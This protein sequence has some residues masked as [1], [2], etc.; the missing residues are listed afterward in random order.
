M[1]WN[2][3]I[4]TAFM[5]RLTSGRLGR[6]AAFAAVAFA[7][8]VAMLGTTLPT[9]LYDL[10]RARF[11]FSE[12]MVTVVFAVYAAGVIGALLVFGHVS[13]QV[14]RRRTLLAGLALS[15]LGAL[16]FLLANGLPLLVIGRILSGLSA[17]LFTGTATATLVDLAP[18]QPRGRAAFTATVA[19]TGGLGLGTL[20]AGIVSQWLDS[21]LQTVFWVDLAL[22]AATAVG[23]WLMPEP[24]AHPTRLNLRPQLPSIPAAVRT[25]FVQA[26][27]G[28]FAGFAVLGLFTAVTPALLAQELAITSRAAIGLVVFAV[29]AASMLG[30]AALDRLPGGAALPVG[31]A[32]LIA[33]MGALALGL[34]SSS[35]VALVVAAVVSG[36]GQGISF[37][38]G[39]TAVTA[40]SPPERRAETVSSLFVVAYAALAVPVV[41]EGLLAATVGL[42]AAGV[43]FAGVVATL[44]AAVLVLLWQRHAVRAVVAHAGAQ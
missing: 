24:V 22:L 33:G 2:S 5:P 11:G 6:R 18:A 1:H 8:S 16:T 44:C 19:N 35:L 41:G 37:R 32:L 25:R 30:Q 36:L 28:V 23:I 34:V 21:P 7:L 38:A 29:F 43:A 4:T 15:A 31:C 20:V 42:Q 17:G 13:D 10:Y 27:I 3:R 12:L 40:E 9:P 26:A 39:M 14:G